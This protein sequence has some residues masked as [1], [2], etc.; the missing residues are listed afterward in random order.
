M[1]DT[2][3]HVG[4]ASAIREGTCHVIT[5]ADEEI[6]VYK[7]DGE[8]HAIR[9]FCPHRGAPI[10]SG[11]ISGT[12]LPSDVGQFVYG[13]EGQV[14]SC[15]WH[16]WQFDLKTG[17]S[18]FDADRRRLIMYAVEVVG[19]ELFVCVP[20]RRRPAEDADPESRSAVG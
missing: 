20:E 6:G 8:I 10:C 14:I 4:Q 15:P 18:L 17:R 2:R 5:V 16:K 19:D 11:M 7:V 3:H 9:N 1:S 12:M 13:L